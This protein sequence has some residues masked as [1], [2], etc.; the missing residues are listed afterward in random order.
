MSDQA[1]RASSG[2]GASQL[3]AREPY[4]GPCPTTVRRASMSDE[5]WEA[6]VAASLAEL[7]GLQVGTYDDPEPDEDQPDPPAVTLYDTPCPACGATG[8]C[9]YDPNGLPLI[10]ADEEAM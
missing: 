10:H 3:P 5:E 9:A 6:D 8:P 1:G 2:S 4:V 7:A